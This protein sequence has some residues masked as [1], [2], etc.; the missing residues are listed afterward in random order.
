MQVHELR[1]CHLSEPGASVEAN[2]QLTSFIIFDLHAPFLEFSSCPFGG[3]VVGCGAY[4]SAAEAI[5]E[6]GAE[7]TVD[8]VPITFQV[9]S[10]SEAPA[11]FTFY[12]PEQNA[13]C[14]AE[15]VSRNR[16][17]RD[18]LRGAKVRDALVWS[19]FI[20]EARTPL[21]ISSEAEGVYDPNVYEHAVAFA[22]DLVRKEDY[23]ISSSERMVEL[24]HQGKARVRG[25]GWEELDFQANEE[26]RE[27]LVRQARRLRP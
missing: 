24:T 8:G 5:R 7:L 14:G 23:T 2:R 19:G 25:F 22:K 16:H 1:G 18:T 4:R 9:V 15:L 21:I 27:E 12:L 10:G 6:T 20:D 26:Q 11:E 3:I 17:N 13:F